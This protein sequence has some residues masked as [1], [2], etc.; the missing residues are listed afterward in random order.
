MAQTINPFGKKIIKVETQFC[1]QPLSLEVGRVGFRTSASVLARYGDT[2]VM[3]TA[4]V[5]PE[6][7]QG[8]DYFP[9]SIDY[10]EKFY[11][12]GKISGSRFI[13]REG[14]PSDEAVLIGRLIDR[15]IRPLWPK[16]YRHEVQGV[17]TVLSMDPNFRPDAIAMIAM[18]AAFMLTGVPFEGPVAS[19]RVGLKD[20]KPQAFLTPQELESGA[21]DL[22]VAGTKDAIMMVEA[23]AREVTE[24]QTV[25]ALEY[26]HKIIRPAIDLQT[27]L[28]KKVG[29][30]PQEYELLLPDEQIQKAVDSWTEDKLGPGLRIPYPE[31]NDLVSDLRHKMHEHFRKKVG[32]EEFAAAKA[33]YDESFDTVVHKDVREGILKEGIRPDGRKLDEIRP[34]SSEVGFLPRAHGSSLFTRGVT[35]AMNIVTL[36]P[37]SYV[38]LIDTMEREG[39]RR[40]LHHYNAPGYTVGE[41]RRL[42]A[43]GRREIGHGYLAERALAAVLPAEAD[44][45]YTIRSVTEIMSQNG[46]TSM[47]ATCSSCMALM[48]AGVPISAPVSGIAMGLMTDGKKAV[49]LSDIADAEDFAGDMDFKVAGTEK[50]ITAL[51]MDMKVHGLP[52]ET[53]SN[54]LEQSKE[55]RSEILRHMVE[56]IPEPRKQ[57]SPYAPRVEAI[58]INPEKIREVIGKGGETIN[59]IIAETGAEIDIKD[60]GTVMIASPDQKSIQAAI[61]FIRTLTAEP[62]V[63]KIYENCRV[64]SVLE[65]GAFVEVLPG[66]EGLVHV[67]EMAEERVNK[68]SDV[69]KEGD[70]VT[71]K[72]VA[73]DDR[74]RLQLS[75]KAAARDLKERKV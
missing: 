17:A 42:G 75:M 47:A 36:A 23:G 13:K 4:M 46:S 62:E 63:G 7:V 21:L 11:A 43:P 8:L 66:K 53:L 55:G 30:T 26:A 9:L 18:S 51:Q 1:G 65:F 16:G 67:S 56:T 74:G 73:I 35:Q 68:P 40:Y 25:E 31:R 49:I 57:M 6:T 33:D 61:Q 20:G 70:K 59:K 54:A 39:E 14:R 41:V 28:A 12:A 3:G 29:V 27:E 19:V 10:E 32:E 45:P 48:D 15:P 64:V 71:V 50:G 72:L 5:S 34:L 69:V 2:V 38:Q 58:T 44:F 22:V 60:D 24:K 37:L 52:I